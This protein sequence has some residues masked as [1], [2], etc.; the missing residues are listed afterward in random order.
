MKAALHRSLTWLTVLVLAGSPVL[1]AQPPVDQSRPTFHSAADLVSIQASVRDKR[2]RPVPGLTGTDFEVRDNGVLRP[3]LSLRSD[4]ES[5]L[6]LAVLVDMSGSMSVGPK[7]AMAR[8]AFASLLSQLRDGQDE[9]AVFTFD[10]AL[11]ERQ[12]F[13]TGIAGL[14]DVLDDFRPFGSTS[15]YD[16]TAVAARRLAARSATHKAIIV[17]TDGIDT[18]STLTASEVSGL[19]SSIDVPVYVVAT[20]PSLD[21]AAIMESTERAAPSNGADLRDLA[22]WTGGSWSSR[23]PCRDCQCRLQTSRRAPPA[24]HPRHRSGRHSRVASAGGSCQTTIDHRQSAERILRRLISLPPPLLV[25]QHEQRVCVHGHRIGT[26]VAA[27]VATSDT[28]A[29]ATSTSGSVGATPNRS[30]WTRSPA[31]TAAHRP[32]S[33]PSV[34][35]VSPCRSMR[36]RTVDGAAPR[37]MR[38]PISRRRCRTK[39]DNVPYVP[40]TDRTSASPAKQATSADWNRGRAS[41]TASNRGSG[42]MLT[43]VAAGSRSATARRIEPATACWGR[44]HESPDSRD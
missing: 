7:I 9:V 10:S 4:R 21:Q 13:T 34:P 37:A 30:G 35:I 17:L 38:M 43:T 29:V 41:G 18:S 3:V 26:T 22:E 11:H 2:G 8:Q 20:V 39:N 14:K 5:P 25:A 19:A 40:T 12:A 23:A 27:T 1:H 33:T 6:S 28:A 16:A 24:V 36:R 42:V 32:S 44:W 15:L 31:A